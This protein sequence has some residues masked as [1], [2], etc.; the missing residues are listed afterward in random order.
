MKRFFL[1]IFLLLSAAT[2]VLALDFEITD[3]DE[4]LYQ[5]DGYRDQGSASNQDQ[6]SGSGN[7]ADDTYAQTRAFAGEQGADYG[8]PRDPRLVVA[9]TIQILLS[10][11][12]TLFLGYTIFAGYT[13]MMARGDEAEVTKGKETLKTAVIGMAIIFS[14]Y[15]ITL[16]VAGV[17]L[18]ASG[19]CY[20]TSIPAIF[21]GRNAIQQVSCGEMDEQNNPDPGDDFQ[22]DWNGVQ[23][24]GEFEEDSTQFIQKDPLR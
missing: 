7:Y 14:A 19:R 9:Y 1:L 11:V 18:S 15:S 13:I 16:F 4:I 8:T 10:I 5:T 17:A 6:T 21:L 3:G 12:G 20:R 2:P 24:D 22:F 23:V